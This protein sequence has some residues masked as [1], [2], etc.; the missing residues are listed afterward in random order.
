[1]GNLDIIRDWQKGTNLRPL[2]VSMTG[3][4]KIQKE[5]QEASERKI[6]DRWID[7]DGREWEKTVYGKKQIPKVLTAIM[8]T[9]PTCPSC[10][11]L[12]ESSNRHDYKMFYKSGMCFDCTIEK[13]T[14]RKVDGSFKDYASLKVFTKQ[15]DELKDVIKMMEES[16]NS[17]EERKDGKM[18][19]LDENGEYTELASFDLKKIKTDLKEDLEKA[20]KSLEELEKAIEKI[21]VS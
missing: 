3:I 10:G 13:D 14:K 19:I 4:E 21:N 20:H 12:I 18:K 8:D 9:R 7:D 11:K 2:S 16:Y 1:M 15:R 5:N 17:I 6:G